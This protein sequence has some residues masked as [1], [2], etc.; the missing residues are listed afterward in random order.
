[1]CI[2]GISILLCLWLFAEMIRKAPLC[3]ENQQPI[4]THEGDP[5]P[6][7]ET[8]YTPEMH[9]EWDAYVDMLRKRGAF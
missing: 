1:M 8:Y 7:Q 5:I 9:R 4:I 2:F 6:S 3:D